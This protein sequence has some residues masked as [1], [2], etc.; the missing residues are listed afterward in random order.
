M[1]NVEIPKEED[2]YK[3]LSNNALE[4]F[5]F[6]LHDMIEM[7]SVKPYQCDPDFFVLSQNFILFYL[8]ICYKQKEKKDKSISRKLVKNIYKDIVRRTITLKSAYENIYKKYF[9]LI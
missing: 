1:F 7:L 2:E 3:K 6:C 8:N 4:R 9:E 5:M